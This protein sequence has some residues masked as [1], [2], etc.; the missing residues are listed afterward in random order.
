MSRSLMQDGGA[1]I[2]MTGGRTTAE[3]DPLLLFK[4]SNATGLASFYI[5]KRILNRDAYQTVTDAWQAHEGS[6]PG[7]EKIIFWRD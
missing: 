5:G 3:D 4:K 7:A 1:F 6:A 2:N